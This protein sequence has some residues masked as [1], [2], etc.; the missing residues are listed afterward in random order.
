MVYERSFAIRLY[1]GTELRALLLREGFG[2]TALYGDFEGHPYDQDAQMLVAVARNT[3][4]GHPGRHTRQ[5]G[6]MH[7]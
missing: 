6:E 4:S 7:R 1:A 2:S 5:R 3:A